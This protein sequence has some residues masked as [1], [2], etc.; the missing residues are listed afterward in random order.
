[1]Q[2]ENIMEREALT[3][4]SL[5]ERLESFGVNVSIIKKMNPSLEDLLEFTGKL[6]ELM[7]N[8]AET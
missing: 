6:Q 3:Q 5:Y 2:R 8:P 1:M 4:E 7:K